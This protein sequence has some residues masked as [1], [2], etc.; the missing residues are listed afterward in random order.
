MEMNQDQQDSRDWIMNYLTQNPNVTISTVMNSHGQPDWVA[1]QNRILDAQ[2]GPGLDV[3]ER[4][5]E[6][7]REASCVE[8]LI[9]DVLIDLEQDDLE[10]SLAVVESPQSET[11]RS[12]LR[13]TT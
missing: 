13:V 10:T 2:G 12:N 4:L 3:D 9:D 1:T 7:D 11:A 5:D 6:L 8:E